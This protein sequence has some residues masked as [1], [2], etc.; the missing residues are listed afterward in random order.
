MDFGEDVESGASGIF[1]K[2]V[3]VRVFVY[4]FV[5]FHLFQV[6][7]DGPSNFVGDV[8]VVFFVEFGVSKLS[9]AFEHLEHHRRMQPTTY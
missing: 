6:S 7:C 9:V 2:E 1:R 4:V 8:I 5:L 3:T